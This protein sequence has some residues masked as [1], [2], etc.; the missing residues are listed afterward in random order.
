[1]DF[2]WTLWI[3]KKPLT[4]RLSCQILATSLEMLRP[5][6]LL[7]LD[8]SQGTLSILSDL[9][10]CL[11][12]SQNEYMQYSMYDDRIFF[13]PNFSHQKSHRINFKKK[14]SQENRQTL[15]T[16]IHIE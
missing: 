11:K 14:S 4:K 1:M 13:V 15:T 16:K 7:R 5:P 3:R 8:L 2:A 10:S 12:D 6:V 9:M